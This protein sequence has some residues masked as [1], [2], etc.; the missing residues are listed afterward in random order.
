MTMIDLTYSQ[1]IERGQGHNIWGGELEA[2][3][4]KLAATE[5]TMGQV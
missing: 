4:F 3:I 1:H 2:T 5:I